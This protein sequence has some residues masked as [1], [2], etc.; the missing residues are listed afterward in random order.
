[1]SFIFGGQRQP[2]SAEKIAAAESEMELIQEMYSK[3]AQH[4]HISCILCSA[5]LMMSRPE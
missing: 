4:V 5:I 2:S 3:Y 1:M